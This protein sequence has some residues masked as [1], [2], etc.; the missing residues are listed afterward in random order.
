M[1]SDFISYLRIYMSIKDYYSILQ[2]PPSASLPEIKKV[3]RQLAQ[4][5]HPDKH[6]NDPYKAAQFA[7]IKEA[8]EILSDPVKKN[9]YLQQRWYNQSIGKK[10]SANEPITAPGILKQCLEL[11]RY[12]ASLD[13]HRMDREGL[14][15]YICD[16]LS[17]PIIEQ[18]KAF[19]E[20][21][22]N[23][24]IINCV[25]NTMKPLQLS[26]ALQVNVQLLKLA[27]KNAESKDLITT[28]L[29]QYQRKEKHK[30]YQPLIILLIAIIICLLIYLLN[31]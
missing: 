14:A 1:S 21:D 22:I 8:Y 31:S 23:K 20:P 17:D 3:F 25:L 4:Q 11:D 7:Q 13:I 29:K 5:Y 16:I 9:Y 28:A 19:N 27:G 10:F 6:N 2:L 30:K 12:V 18:L 26:Q 15:A 24:T